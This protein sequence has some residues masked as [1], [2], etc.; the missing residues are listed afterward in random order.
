MPFILSKE[1]YKAGMEK[2]TK[3]KIWSGFLFLLFNSSYIGKDR[4]GRKEQLGFCLQKQGHR[5]LC[6]QIVIT[7]VASSQ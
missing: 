5:A 2:K 1:E 3:D 7:T 6:W 4:R